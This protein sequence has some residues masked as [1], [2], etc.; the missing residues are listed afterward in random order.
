MTSFSKTPH[1]CV[2]LINRAWPLYIPDLH[3]ASVLTKLSVEARSERTHIVNYCDLP[4]CGKGSHVFGIVYAFCKN[5][6]SDFMANG[7]YVLFVRLKF[8]S[9]SGRNLVTR[10]AL[11]I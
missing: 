5:L 2:F 11:E 1:G 7:G 3:L 9:K 8:M 10:D 6:A 4:D